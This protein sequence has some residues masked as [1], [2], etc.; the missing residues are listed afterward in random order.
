M[1]RGVSD[2]FPGSPSI[3]QPDYINLFRIC[4]SRAFLTGCI[5]G[6]RQ[7]NNERLMNL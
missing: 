5:A 3:M 6:N 4:E 2:L 7:G 1:A